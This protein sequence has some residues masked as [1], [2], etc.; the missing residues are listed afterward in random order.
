MRSARLKERDSLA[1]ALSQYHADFGSATDITSIVSADDV[2]SDVTQF[3]VPREMSTTNTTDKPPADGALLRIT[4]SSKED[5]RA[6]CNVYVWDGIKKTYTFNRRSNP[7]VALG[8][9]HYTP[10]HSAVMCDGV[11]YKIWYSTVGHVTEC[12][13]QNIET[14]EYYTDARLCVMDITWHPINFHSDFGRDQLVFC[15]INN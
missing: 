1:H 3:S 12:T 10:G 15:L 13:V 7:D 5:E 8:F 9:E 2:P 4:A 14:L 11:I 6:C